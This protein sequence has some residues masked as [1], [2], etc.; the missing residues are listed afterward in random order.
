MYFD[1]DVVLDLRMNVLDEHIDYFVIVESTFTHKGDARKLKF[2]IEKFPNFK[3]K[4]IYLVYDNEPKNIKKISNDENETNKSIKYIL[5]A[6][7][8]ENGQRNFISE[9]L[10]RAQPDDLIL[11]SDVDEI[12]NLMN[13]DFRNFKEK[14]LIFKQDMF[15]YKFNLR[16]P[17]LIWSGTKG[18]KK[19]D[20]L[21]PQWLRNIKDRKYSFYRLDT[22][23]SKT[24][25]INI[26]LI[27]NGGWH[28]SNLKT[29]KEIEYKL[30]SYLHHR[31][32]DANP[33][34]SD[35]I[36]EIMKNKIAIYDLTL[37]KRE[38]KFGEGKKLEKCKID[39]LPKYLN[40][41][42]TTYKEWLD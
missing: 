4:I 13:F 7:Y 10:K 30:K 22:F 8:R 40:E 31:E 26:K 9:G 32:F 27:D 14:I 6:A 15:Y 19:K 17:N 3:D 1:E 20:L 42:Q 18:C 12:P 21:N 28:F 33:I 34:S 36:N 11:I 39:I 29:A 41:N 2:N 37:D 24:K 25:Y 23:F 38:R 5:N 16:L 35:K